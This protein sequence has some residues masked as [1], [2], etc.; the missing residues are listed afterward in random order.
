MT[1]DP[2]PLTTGPAPSKPRLRRRILLILLLILLALLVKFILHLLLPRNYAG[3]GETLPLKLES[4]DF[5]TLYYSGTEAPLGI[6][7]VGTGDGGWSYWEERVAKHLAGKNYAVGGWDCRKF[8]DTR[9]FNQSQL[10]AAWTAAA[11]AVRERAGLPEDAPVWYGGW[12]TG[13][14]WAA[15]AAADPARPDSFAG[16]LLAAPGERS[17]YGLTKGD[18]LGLNPTGPGTFALA[19]LAPQLTDVPVAQFSAG[20]DPLDDATWLEQLKSPH[21][22]IPISGVLHDMDGAGGK[23]LAEWDRAMEWTLSARTAPPLPP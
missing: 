8:A 14:E 10:A 18:L 9:S 12:S 11:A 15:A 5:S 23:F 6:V 22:L 1:A 16:L 19:D 13:A 7:I 2:S 3:S 20:L 21:R 4:G 17:R